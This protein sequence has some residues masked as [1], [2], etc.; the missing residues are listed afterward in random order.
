GEA[1]RAA[2][3]APLIFR[4]RLYGVIEL[5]DRLDGRPFDARDR[6]TLA[7]Y[8]PFVAI[9]LSHASTVQALK[10]RSLK[11]PETETYNL[12]YFVDYAGKEIYKA[13]RY[14]RKFS[15]LLLKLDN[16]AI[17]R[18]TLKPERVRE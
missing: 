17:M 18:Q 9:A 3:R 11:D 12:L 15:L 14:G 6:E 8:A 7:M 13:R 16:L 1:S 4:K 2:L 5:S 10:R